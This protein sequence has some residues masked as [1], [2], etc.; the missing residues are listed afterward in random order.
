[1]KK[2]DYRKLA[3][4][5]RDRLTPEERI[6]KSRKIMVGLMA[7]ENWKK[8][9]KVLVYCSYLTEV[10]TVDLIAQAIHAH[11]KVYCPKITDQTNRQM[12]FYRIYSQKD[13]KPGFKGIAEPVT[14]EKYIANDFSDSPGKP[15]MKLQNMFISPFHLSYSSGKNVLACL[16]LHPFPI[17][18]DARG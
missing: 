11:K 8:A 10:S 7:T 18:I 1:M 13:L 5:R 12:E 4:E 9:E 14:Q 3:L 17:V 6:D 16:P 15:S 2:E